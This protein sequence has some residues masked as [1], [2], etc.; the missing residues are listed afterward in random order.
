[1]NAL[2]VIFDDIG[3]DVDTVRFPQA[4]AIYALARL[5]GVTA[6]ELSSVYKRFGLTATS[7]N[8][9][10]LIKHGKD[11]DALTQRAARARL[12]VGES[13]TAR[14][15]DKLER[16]GL[17]RRVPGEDRRCKLLH[18]TPKGSQLLDEVWPHHT[19]AM[20]RLARAVQP[21]ETKVLADILM[22]LRRM[23]QAP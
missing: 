18:I 19:E 22:R 7:F 16:R 8:L 13:E 21:Q 9:L 10:M 2:R 15:V 17:I 12:I 6:R 3:F 20:S 5:Y 4:A 14:I 11:R 1:M 23:Q